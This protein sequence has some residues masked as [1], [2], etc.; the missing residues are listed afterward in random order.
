ME[1]WLQT[2]WPELEVYCNSVTEQFATASISGPLARR[3][4]AELTTGIDLDRDAFPFMSWRDGHVAGLPAR[5]ARVSFTGE[6]SFEINVP[7]GYGLSLWTALMH[8]GRRYGITPY[9]TEA[10]HVLRAERGFIHRRAGNRRH[11]D[12]DTTLAWSW[13]VSRSKDFLGKRSLDRAD[14]SRED[15]KQL[16]GLLT[17]N[18]EDVLPEGGQI[19]D[20]VDRPSHAHDRPRHVELLQRQSGAVH[21]PRARRGRPRAPRRAGHGSARA[22]RGVRAHHRAAVLRSQRRACAWLSGIDATARSLT[23]GSKP[24]RRPP[25][26]HAGGDARR[27]CDARP[28]RAARRRRERRISGSAVCA[29]CSES[30]PSSS[31]WRPPESATCRCF[32]W[33]RTS[34]SS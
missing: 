11:G 22:C 25:S 17:D 21:R 30:N 4:L 12:S 34:G 13:I 29:P 19:V 33:D 16:V 7:S 18:P 14:T 2:E 15:R 20:T 28:A 6:S 31:R 1:E 9:G 8:S 32:G 24:E 10:M 23:S 27:V 5:V 26:P 3:L